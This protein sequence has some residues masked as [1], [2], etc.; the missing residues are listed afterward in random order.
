MNIKDRKAELWK[1]IREL[2]SELVK[3]KQLESINSYRSLVG[4]FFMDTYDKTYLLFFTV[5]EVDEIG[6]PYGYWF[7]VF[8][9]A[10]VCGAGVHFSTT[11]TLTNLRPYV[12]NMGYS[13]EITKINYDV[14]RD[15]WVTQL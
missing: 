5:V 6:I 2:N 3:L 7:K 15:S 8:K 1:Q 13:K 10:D 14:V 11:Q 4:K 12:H 9:K